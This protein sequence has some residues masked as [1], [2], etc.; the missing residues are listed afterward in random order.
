[1]E[2]ARSLSN[3][4]PPFA[5]R[6]PAIFGPAQTADAPGDAEVVVRQLDYVGSRKRNREGQ[7]KKQK[8]RKAHVSHGQS[9]YSPEMS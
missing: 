1:M 6:S 4:S 7:Q 2:F 9:L 3:A 8:K 5:N